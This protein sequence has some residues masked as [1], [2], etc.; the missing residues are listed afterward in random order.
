[1]KT[2][3]V[4]GAHGFVGRHLV[5]KLTGIGYHVTK[6]DP[7]ATLICKGDL[8]SFKMSFESWLV[9]FN[10]ACKTHFDLVVHLGAHIKD[11]NARMHAGITAYED[12]K[13]DYEVCKYVEATKPG[14]FIAMSSC[15]VD[16]VADPY[17]VVKR[18]LEAFTSTLAK[19]GQQVRVL[20][21]FSGYGYDQ[22]LDY[23]FPA[24]LERV[25]TGENPVT[26]WGGKQVRDWLHIDDLVDGVIHSIDNFPNGVPVELG[27][28]KGATFYQLAEFM[29]AAYGDS[30]RTVIGDSTKETSSSYRVAGSSSFPTIGQNYGWYPYIT[31]EEGIK[32]EM[33]KRLVISS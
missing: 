3:L 27:T 22:T 23:P 31:L 11:V 30:T 16:Y 28:C 6:V 4:I 24:I 9:V 18:T 33:A 5:P 20:R 26:V 25:V 13:L 17:C 8:Y 29:L 10:K 12:I 21:P 7:A 2:A 19:N 15:A 1:M 32:M 14:C